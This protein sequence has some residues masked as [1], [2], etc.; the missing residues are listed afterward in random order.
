MTWSVWD[1]LSWVY[2]SE[3]ICHNSEY[4]V[5]QFGL[6]GRDSGYWCS[7]VFLACRDYVTVQVHSVVVIIGGS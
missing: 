4:G 7:F 5:L 2:Y 1:V 3:S 6:K